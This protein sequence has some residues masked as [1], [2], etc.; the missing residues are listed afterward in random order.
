MRSIATV[1]A[2]L[3]MRVATAKSS[4]RKHFNRKT[5]HPCGGK[6][7]NN[8]LC[9]R[10]QSWNRRWVAWHCCTT[11]TKLT[12]LDAWGSIGSRYSLSSP[13]M[14]TRPVISR[15]LFQVRLLV[16]SLWSLMKQCKIHGCFIGEFR[17]Q[18]TI[19]DGWRCRLVMNFALVWWC[20]WGRP[21]MSFSETESQLEQRKEA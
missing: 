5:I 7:Y 18:S 1:H 10:R 6:L 21:L 8:W 15:I 13:S 9:S 16:I 4:A 3:R 11:L 2:L 14:V 20:S 19:T 17:S 12:L